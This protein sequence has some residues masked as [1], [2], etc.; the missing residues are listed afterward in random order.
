M[1]LHV[2]SFR[3]DKPSAEIFLWICHLGIV[4]TKNFSALYG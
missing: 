3:D 2:L 1:A 4:A